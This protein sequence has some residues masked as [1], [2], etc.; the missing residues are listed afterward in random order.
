MPLYIESDQNCQFRVEPCLKTTSIENK[1]SAFFI[2]LVCYVAKFLRTW[3]HFLMQ[4]FFFK[5]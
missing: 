1:G 2:N 4:K 3:V 5:C